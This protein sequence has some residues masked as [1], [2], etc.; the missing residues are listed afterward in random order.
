MIGHRKQEPHYG[1]DGVKDEGEKHVLMEGNSL[2]AETPGREKQTERGKGKDISSGFFRLLNKHF[3]SE[4][5]EI[6]NLTI[7]PPTIK[8]LDFS[9]EG[10]SFETLSLCDTKT[11]LEYSRHGMLM[12]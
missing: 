7:L 2:A 10:K 6:L 12:L 11:D 9:A 1:N 5:A 8:S 3:G 4:I